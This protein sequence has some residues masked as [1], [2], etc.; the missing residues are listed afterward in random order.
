MIFAPD[1]QWAD[2]VINQCSLFPR[3]SRDDLVDSTTQ[4]LRWL[5]ETGFALKRSEYEMEREG[6]TAYTGQLMPLYPV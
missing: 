2:M 5:R 4:A 6:E 3:G 1:K